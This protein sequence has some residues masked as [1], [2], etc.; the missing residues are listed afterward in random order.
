[1][2]IVVLRLG[3]RVD[4]DQR[5]TTHVGLCARALG[6]HG[7]LLA[8]S[9]HSVVDTMRDVVK[10]WGGDFW[11]R[12]NV[13]W[14]EEIVKWKRELGTVVHLTMYGENLPKAVNRLKANKLMVVVGAEKVPPDLYH[15]ADYNV[16]VTNQPHSEIAALSVF[17]DHVQRGQELTA[18]FAGKTKIVG[19]T[20]NKVGVKSSEQ[21]D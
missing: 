20:G 19:N 1:M 16:A 9:D 10:R 7:M 15:L 6:A 5:V 17:L 21:I 12:D 8:A 18:D 14:R 2:E 13:N 3:H 11:V 4:R